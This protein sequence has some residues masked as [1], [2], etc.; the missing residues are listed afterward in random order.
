MEVNFVESN[1]NVLKFYCGNG[2][3]PLWLY[4]KWMNHILETI[5]FM[6]YKLWINK[7]TW[8]KCSIFQLFLTLVAAE[9]QTQMY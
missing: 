3:M 2:G 6:L 5:D 7:N 1:E 8:E 4:Q 9:I